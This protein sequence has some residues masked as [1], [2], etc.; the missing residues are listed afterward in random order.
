MTQLEFELPYDDV[1]GHYVIYLGIPEKVELPAPHKT[2]F[3][4]LLTSQ[5]VNHRKYARKVRTDSDTTFSKGSPIDGQTTFISCIQ[6]LG[7]I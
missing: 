5:L 6:A 2:A 1:T 3:V 4:R 7:A